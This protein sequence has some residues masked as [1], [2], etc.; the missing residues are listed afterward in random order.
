MNY[1][2]TAFL[3]LMFVF[4]Q[5]KCM[6]KTDV[7]PLFIKPLENKVFIKEKGQFSRYAKEMNM[8][9]PEPVLYGIENAEF[10]AYFTTHG[11]TFQ[12]PERR[13]IEKSEEEMEDKEKEGKEKEEEKTIETIWHAVN[14]QWLNTNPLV[15][16]IPEEKVADY[17]NYDSFEDD[18]T[19]YDF[20]PAFKKLKYKNLYPGVD[21]EFELSEKGGIKYK[22][23]VQPNVVIPE[24]KFQWDGLENLSTDEKGDL[25]LKSLFGE[26]LDRAP[27]ANSKASLTN[28]PVKYNVQ[29]NIVQF[30]FSSENIASPEGIVIDPWITNTNYSDLNRAFDVQEDSL[31][32]IFTH[33]NHSNYHIEKYNSSG[34]L[35]WSYVTYSIFLGDIAVDNPGN[36]YIIGGY[37][38]GKRQKLDTAGVQLW[39]FSGLS[40]EWR[41][42]FNYSKTTLA[43]CGYFINPGGNN[44]ARLDMATGAVSDQIAY[45]EE[46]RS[47]ATDCNG[48]MYSLHLPTSTL[49]KTNAD[50]TPAGVVPSGLNLIYSGVG[51]AL[52]PD[53]SSAVYQGF[54]GTLIQGPYV[55][56][57]DGITLRR[58]NK[59]TLAF[60]NDVSVP[61][62]VN[63]QCSGLAVDPCGYIYAGTT[64]SIIKFDS[65]LNYMD[66]IPVPG[67]V[68]DVILTASGDLLACGEGFIGKFSTSCTPPPPLT[69]NTT[70]FCEGTTA[71]V[72][73]SGGIAP[74]SYFWEPGGQTTAAVSNL[75][76]GTYSITVSDPFCHSY[77]DSI[78]IKPKALAAFNNTSVC[79]G[80]ATLFTDG[81]TT[82]SGNLASW[83][84]DFGDGSP[85]STAQ[86]PTYTYPNA[87]N[88]NATLVTNNSF[89]CADTIIKSV[90]V[91]YNPVAGFT[92]S[93]VCFGDTLHFIDVSSVDPSASITSY[94]WVFADGSPISNLPSPDHYYNASG[95]YNVTLVTNTADG[96]SNAVSN[97][98]NIYGSPVSAFTFSN[99]CLLDSVAFTNT[100]IN[101]TMGTIASWSWDF[102]DGSPL[103]TTVW[104][105]LHSYSSPGNYLVTL[106]TH[107]STLGCPDTI[108]TTIT[109]HPLPILTKTTIN[110]TCSGVCD[111]QI[112][113]ISNGG[114]APYTYVWTGGCTTDSCINICAGSY[115][116]TVTD[117]FGCSIITDTTVTEPTALV[118]SITNSTP[119]SCNVICDGTVTA[120]AAGGTQGAGYSFL[121]NT[122]P[123][124]NSTTA[125]GLCVGTYT[126][127]ITDANGCAQTPV[128]S[129]TLV[130]GPFVTAS[131][132]EYSIL[133]GNNIQLTA[134]GGNNYHWSPTTGLN[135]DTC[136]STTA[137]PVQTITYCVL[138]T[139][140]NACSDSACV[141]INVDKPCPDFAVPN[142]F[143]PNNDGH[144]DKFCLQGWDN[145]VTKFNILIY[146]RWGEKVFESLDPS[147]CWDG[148]LS[149]TMLSAVPGKPL[150]SAVFVYSITA[151]LK[152]GE[153]ISRKG[154]ISLIR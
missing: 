140:V 63:Y 93:D 116:V 83:T 51:Y 42:A 47:I 65:A 127:T 13:K 130:P 46:T 124:Q 143:S 136:Q 32:N 44:L 77:R 142:A 19:R 105:P 128:A 4:T 73:V 70:T 43:I 66:S 53:Y 11:I 21:A 18:K 154:N 12:F 45:N 90:H 92:H 94:L 3:L 14:L 144:N 119:T 125:T 38:A 35:Q 5:F 30:Q 82:T 54:N 79:N 10:N 78:I 147:F 59:T 17:Y 22:F 37:T 91:Y 87:G 135:C 7:N 29:N 24:I 112:H 33:G 49:R 86:S 15:E 81:S 151:T 60:I 103:N 67:F 72:N 36:V 148:T 99:T 40:E 123:A 150:L 23:I 132:T 34:I 84:W 141:T 113:V 146:D 110:A 68:Y 137:S 50:F 131:A 26:L 71:T 129:V 58:F 114:T 6:A 98:I 121:W 109:I 1:I 97:A 122:V 96:C 27:V 31:G 104:S 153:K 48:D 115:S 25:H 138:V 52:N 101:P 107:S 20:V 56:I 16:L 9:F 117:A 95:T 134:S 76:A 69:F 108:K 88:Y 41:L 39:S 57:Y 64:N 28:I 75:A 85:V 62:G 120:S 89:G 74:Y 118:A 126:C 55:Y 8:L 139:D 2:R 111:G 102:G 149:P 106:I 145:C 100:S 152:S 80:N 61:N 133:V